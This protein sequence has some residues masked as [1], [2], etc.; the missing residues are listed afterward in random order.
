MQRRSVHSI[1]P[2]TCQL[3]SASFSPPPLSASDACWWAGASSC[4]ELAITASPH[5]RAGAPKSKPGAAR[6][7]GARAILSKFMWLRHRPPL[8]PSAGPQ[9]GARRTPS[10]GQD[11]GG[12]D[13]HEGTST[14]RRS[15][16]R[17]RAASR[18]TTPRRGG[19]RG[20]T[21]GGEARRAAPGRGRRSCSSAERGGCSRVIDGGK[22]A[23]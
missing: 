12:N 1:L 14:M 18:Q 9:G 17:V 23:G 19:G 7:G 11:A 21:G 13:A 8:S 20:D 10:I 22:F 16:S 5:G 15:P 6:S 2:S 3:W 4:A